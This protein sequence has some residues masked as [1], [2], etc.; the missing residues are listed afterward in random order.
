V[1]IID[2]V[3]ALMLVLRILEITGF[4]HFIEQDHHFLWLLHAIYSSLSGAVIHLLYSWPST[5]L[6]L[7][8]LLN[9]HTTSILDYTNEEVINQLLRAECNMT[10]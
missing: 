7:L 1:R 10:V 5:C 4:S 3:L 2:S 9:V 6:S 8:W